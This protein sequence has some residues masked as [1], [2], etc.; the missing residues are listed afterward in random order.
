MD[1]ADLAAE[2]TPLPGELSP[3]DGIGWAKALDESELQPAAGEPK[4][5]EETDTPPSEGPVCK[6]CGLPIE[7]PDGRNWS[8]KRGRRPSFH[9]ACRPSSA[10][11]GGGRTTAPAKGPRNRAEREADEIAAKVR[12]QM[13]T[14]A[15]FVAMVEP[16][17]G[18]AIYAGSRQFS[19]SVGVVAQGNERFRALM[20][21]GRQSAGWLGLIT[22]A[23]LIAAPI[24]AHHGLI[25]ESIKVGKGKP[26]PVGEMLE[27]L[28]DL[29]LNLQ[30]KMDNAE[31]EIARRVVEAQNK[32]TESA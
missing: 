19:N 26:M 29:L 12:R 15:L 21:S 8:G 14:F 3:S 17:D 2:T 30:K 7:D 23:A 27:M 9:P 13:A 5:P 10:S 31:S 1:L 6:A 11:K 16:F 18:H 4:A 22:S 20:L 28:P 25:P 24:A 32:G